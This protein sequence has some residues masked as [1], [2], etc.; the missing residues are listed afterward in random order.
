M[1]KNLIIRI[2]LFLL[3]IFAINIY[4]QVTIRGVVTDESDLPL[5]NT[6]I[7]V[8]GTTLGT[9][10]DQN[11]RY[12]LHIEDPPSDSIWISAKFVGYKT[13]RKSVKATGEIELD[14]TLEYDLLKLDKL[15]VTGSAAPVEKSKL[16]HTI[17]SVESEELQNVGVQQIDAA[18]SGKVPGALVQ[19][20][21]GNTGGGTSVRLRGIS[22]LFSGTSDPL[23]IVDGI[24]IDNSAS[25]LISIGGNSTNRL[26]DLDP[27]DI[28]S[29][30]IV[31]G[32]ASAAMYGSRANDGVVQIF[33]KRGSPGELDISYK[34]SV[35]FD[36]VIKKYDMID[37]PYARIDGELKE[38]TRYDYQDEIFQR[39]SR[40]DNRLSVSGGDNKTRFFISG[41]WSNRNGIIKGDNYKKGNLRLNLDREIA[42]W[43]N[44]SLSTNYINSTN[45]QTLNG[46][47]LGGSADGF[48]VLTS[49]T[50]M[51][52]Y[53]NLYPDDNG[54]Y[55]PH[56]WSAAG[57][58]NPLE[59][60]N[61]W[62]APEDINRLLAGFKINLKPT[63]KLKVKYQF[64]LDNYNQ[65]AKLYV[66]RK[67][68]NTRWPNGYSSGATK[69]SF[70]INSD[71]S[72][73]YNHDFSKNLHTTS[74][75]G[76]NYQ[77]D[78]Y[79]QIS[80]HTQ[81][82][83]PLVKTLSGAVTYDNVSE[84]I[85]NRKLLGFYIQET[86]GVYDRFFLTSSLRADASSTFGKEQRW[87]LFPKFSSSY[88]ISDHAFWSAIA[89]YVPSM[90][91]RGAIGWSGGQPIDSYARFTNYSSITYDNK[92]GLVNSSIMGNEELK[93][94]RMREWE[95][96][97]DIEFY[98]KRI[99]LELTYFD[100]RVD[101]LIL[102]QIV[103]PSIGYFTQYQ[104]AGVLTNHGIEVLLKT[105]PINKKSFDWDLSISYSTNNPIIEELYGEGV[106]KALSWSQAY[107]VE[108]KPP[109][110][111]RQ[112]TIDYNT[113]DEDGLPVINSEYEFLGDPNPDWF[114]SLINN[115]KI[116]NNLTA[117]MQ[118]DAVWGWEIFDWDTWASRHALWQWHPDYKKEF[119]GEL[120][121]GYNS[122]I[123]SALGEFIR[124]ASFV[125]MREVSISY[126]WQNKVFTSYG[127]DNIL[128]TLT[129]RN[130]FT[131][132]DYTGLDPETN[133]AG[134][135][136]LIRGWNWATTP[137]PRSLLFS[138]TLNL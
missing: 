12:Y 37:Y 52:N 70:Q 24:I 19:V 72:I 36:E 26:A 133:C 61:E 75:A 80:S 35:G 15:V 87:Q 33:T 10:T 95:V 134:Q 20:N 2:S 57:R 136:T 30:E 135:E 49:L 77:H 126:R 116:G 98:K 111:W 38:V 44:I 104:N 1:K 53:H 125:K 56:P 73:F 74:V 96:G 54:I 127:I 131:I 90:N 79:D 63:E 100:K 83:I 114:G 67:T 113:L 29:I 130:L 105:A 107:L 120:P 40:Y 86:I 117:R 45:K 9:T 103:N 65:G 71:L 21:S 118:F 84:F 109:T 99:G 22:T 6:N 32:A 121:E 88:K 122:R 42:D 18:L 119:E 31:K 3:C 51:K 92:T 28:K 25:A 102:D 132:T 106:M 43:L 93:P 89:E 59:V 14:F 85:D 124:D 55:P 68:Q 11:G 17:S 5:Q 16:G 108:G 66:P 41:A 8:D 97:A 46:G 50:Q 81:D 7:V 110:V 94:E 82:L 115:F 60:L 78:E 137:I 39:G 91:L 101:D 123:A 112:R 13:Q 27:E 62:E 129:G 69:N 4:A 47:V 34:T 128:L 138:L 58:A 23:Y 64:G 48:G 76:M